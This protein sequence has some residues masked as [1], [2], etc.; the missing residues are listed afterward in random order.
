M[1]H[2]FLTKG[3]KS[4]CWWGWWLVSLCNT[5]LTQLQT[6]SSSICPCPPRYIKSNHVSALAMV[7]KT[8]IKIKLHSQFIQRRALGTFL[9]NHLGDFHAFLL[10]WQKIV[11]TMAILQN[12]LQAQGSEVSLPRE[13][14]SFMVRIHTLNK[15]KLLNYKLQ[16]P[17]IEYWSWHFLWTFSFLFFIFLSQKR[18]HF[19]IIPKA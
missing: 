8:N 10:S 4:L 16:R 3:C 5:T 13:L 17:N 12:S 6:V 19:K 1:L 18:N 11:C 9:G 7:K 14:P 15:L 2:Q